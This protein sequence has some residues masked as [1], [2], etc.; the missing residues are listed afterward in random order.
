[1]LANKAATVPVNVPEYLLFATSATPGNNETQFT[2]LVKPGG[3]ELEF[4]P[5]AAVVFHLVV[6]S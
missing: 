5:V 4:P 6:A 3:K 1:M 2:P